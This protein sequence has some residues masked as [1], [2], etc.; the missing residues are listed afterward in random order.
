MP[1][2]RP[3]SSIDLTSKGKAKSGKMN[4]SCCWLICKQLEIYNMHD[5]RNIHTP[6][7]KLPRCPWDGHRSQLIRAQLIL[8]GGPTMLV[9]PTSLITITHA[10]CCTIPT[11]WLA[12]SCSSL[13]LRQ[14]AQPWNGR[15]VLGCQHIDP[16]CVQALA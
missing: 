3:L 5:S 12:R 7:S 11:T 1:V 10:A 8:A 14:V 2:P 4:A 16:G 9:F 13:S 6:L 15:I